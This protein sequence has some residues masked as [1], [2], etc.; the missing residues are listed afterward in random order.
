MY[1]LQIK[2]NRLF[3]L[4]FFLPPLFY[5]TKKPDTP[6]KF[7][8]EKK[9]KIKHVRGFWVHNSYLNVSKGYWVHLI[10]RQ[11]S[12]NYMKRC[13]ECV[14]LFRPFEFFDVFQS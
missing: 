9:K 2:Q 1:C 8:K 3:F 11:S 10:S 4:L 14:A 13:P 12:L 6:Y 5:D 7:E